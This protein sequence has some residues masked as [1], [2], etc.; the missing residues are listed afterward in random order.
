MNAN[1][2]EVALTKVVPPRA[3]RWHRVAVYV[4]ALCAAWNLWGLL[5]AYFIAWYSGSEAENGLTLHVAYCTEVGLEVAAA[6]VAVV[7]LRSR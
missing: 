6:I 5:T 3:A 2:A 7:T 4:L 1:A